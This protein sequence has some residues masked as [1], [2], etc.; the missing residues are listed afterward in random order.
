MY[1]TMLA[2]TFALPLASNNP[3]GITRSWRATFFFCLGPILGWPFVGLMALPFIFEQCAL[4]AGDVAKKEEMGGLL[5]DRTRRL[6]GAGI[7][8]VVLISVSIDRSSFE[9][10][11]ELNRSYYY[12]SD[13]HRRHRLVG[14]RTSRLPQS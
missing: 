8:S 4:R 7:L 14:L 2:F 6:I 10:V 3:F 5:A 13:P 9:A 11:I 12:A 1:T